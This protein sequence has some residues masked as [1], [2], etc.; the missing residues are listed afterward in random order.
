LPVNGGKARERWLLCTVQALF[1]AGGAP[2][3]DQCTMY[4]AT[5]FALLTS[6]LPFSGMDLPFL[7]GGGLLL[8]AIGLALSLRISRHEPPHSPGVPE[9][10]RVGVEPERVKVEA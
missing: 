8:A 4:V 5:A 2:A 10:Q 7:L 1:E 6:S 9:V 3:L